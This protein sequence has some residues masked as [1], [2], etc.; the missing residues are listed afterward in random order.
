MRSDRLQTSHDFNLENVVELFH[1]SE[2]HK[3]KAVNIQ[4][5]VCISYNS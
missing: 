2:N 3:I 1:V 4:A 5:V